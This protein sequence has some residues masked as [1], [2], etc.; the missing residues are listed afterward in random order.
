MTSTH[1]KKGTEAWPS[2][3]G[4]GSL[5]SH[6]LLGAGFCLRSCTL[7]HPSLVLPN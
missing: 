5:I 6:V 2:S 4:F 7:G 1:L 3:P